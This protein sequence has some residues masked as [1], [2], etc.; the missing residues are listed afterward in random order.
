M[1]FINHRINTIE[2][3]KSVP[4][5]NGVELDVRYHNNDLILHHDPF[6]HQNNF[7][8]RF[9]DFLKQWRHEGPL[10]INVKTEGVEEECISMMES[11]EVKKWFF[12]DVS[13]PYM[14]TYSLMAKEKNSKLSPDNLA[15][16]FSEYEPIEYALSFSGRA[17]WVWVDCFKELPLNEEIYL[18]LKESDFKICIVSPELQNKSL[19]MISD[20]K[21]IIKDM[22]IEAVCTKR[23]DLW[24]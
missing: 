3:L 21:K 20:F 10:I 18:K 4:L 23:P 8:E 24:Q 22:E 19:E 6:D 16:R 2:Q 1:I 15:V 14:V 12:L 11:Y 5:E 7:S 9:D 13:M 17:R